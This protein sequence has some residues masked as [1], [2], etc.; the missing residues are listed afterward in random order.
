[1]GAADVVS[2]QLVQ[3]SRLCV[4]R[5]FRIVPAVGRMR[6][7][8]GT[9]LPFHLE[10]VNAEWSS[11]FSIFSC[12][13]PDEYFRRYSLQIPLS[14]SRELLLFVSNCMGHSERYANLPF[15]FVVVRRRSARLFTSFRDE[16]LGIIVML[17]KVPASRQ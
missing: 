7:E 10:D 13:N 4:L 3:S 9:S 11:G 16:S 17:V 8:S 6:P 15:H 1:M 12:S 5:R 14:I 2:S